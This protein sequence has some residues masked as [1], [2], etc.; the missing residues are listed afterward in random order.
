VKKW[1]NNCEETGQQEPKN[2]LPKAASP[3][4][5]QNI[6]GDKATTAPDND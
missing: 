4:L 5:L 3:L 2:P 1:D 6:S